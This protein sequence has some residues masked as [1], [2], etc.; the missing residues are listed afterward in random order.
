MQSK[1]RSDIL[2]IQKKS[3]FEGENTLAIDINRSQEASKTLEELSRSQIPDP[4]FLEHLLRFLVDESVAVGAIG[5]ADE[6]GAMTPVARFVETTNDSV[7]LGMSEQKHQAVLKAVSETGKPLLV[8]LDAESAKSA[9]KESGAQIADVANGWPSIGFIPAR[10]RKSQIIIELIFSPEKSDDDCRRSLDQAFGLVSPIAARTNESSEKNSERQN[11]RQRENDGVPET[12]HA[13]NESI[14]KFTEVVQQ[15]L[16]SQIAGGDSLSQY[17][18]A[19]HQSVD[20]RETTYCIAN[21]TRAF[22]GCD[23]VVVLKRSRGKFR[24]VAISGQATVNRRA[25][26]CKRL[27]KLGDCV[28]QSG[29]VLIYP[30]D[31]EGTLPVEVEEPLNDY[32]THSVARS[33]VIFPITNRNPPSDSTI[34]DR[35]QETIRVI[36]GVILEQNTQEI[37]LSEM[38]LAFETVNKHITDS[39][40]SAY[41]HQQLFLYPLWRAVGK[42]KVILATRHLPKTIVASI[43]LT[44]VA[45]AL[46]FLPAK[47]HVTCEGMLVPV[48]RSSVFAQVDGQIT[49]VLTQHGNTVQKGD[50]LA[51]MVSNSLSVKIQEV[52]G[53]I[54][55]LQ[56]RIEAIDTMLLDPGKGYQGANERD[57]VKIERSSLVSQVSSLQSQLTILGKDKDNLVIRSPLS[58]KITS[59]NLDEYLLNRPVVPGKV[60]MEV[61]DTDGL[62]ELQLELPDKR[63]GHVLT[64]QRDLGTELEVSFI[65]AADPTIRYTGRVVQISNRTDPTSSDGQAI[66]LV[67]DFDNQQFD[68]KQVRTEVT[69]KIYCGKRSLGYVWLHDLFEFV[70]RKVLFRLW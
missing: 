12:D 7:N 17:I 63:I 68:L 57:A 5:W 56:K 28:L 48:E 20:L 60:L 24:L 36:G 34:I 66:R 11:R 46:V 49:Q 55:S 50:R 15:H 37:P 4:V 59:W 19:L 69:A 29:D 52:T 3:C 40:R 23:R 13:F 65:L 26:Q 42:S 39:F 41:T 47:F 1:I 22:L 18:H 44:V 51:V 2:A 61:A 14:G 10:I 54:A 31:S 58:G 43:A 25:E 6:N 33:L 62:W 16:T 9:N 35:E 38:Q 32:L 45:F 64:A 30:D 67:V 70:H 21:E 27:E 53:Q 8:R